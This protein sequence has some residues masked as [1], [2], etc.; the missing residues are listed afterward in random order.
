MK[1]HHRLLA[2]LLITALLF[3]CTP[4]WAFSEPIKAG[5][6][7]SN[8]I[9]EATDEAEE[10][11][12]TTLAEGTDPYDQFTGNVGSEDKKT[13]NVFV[14]VGRGM[15]IGRYSTTTGWEKAADGFWY[16]TSPVAPKAATDVLIQ[17]CMQLRSAA[18]AGYTLSVEVIASAIQAT[19][20]NV[21]KDSWN[22]G[23]SGVNDS[24]LFIKEVEQ[25]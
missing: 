22:S 4:L 11:F 20:D 13:Y 21:V 5:D 2:A 7:P 15:T 14:G 19:P 12:I 8:A 10:E 9:S 18:P 16:Y 17:Q 24:T 6:S 3:G 23:V 25:P 1:K